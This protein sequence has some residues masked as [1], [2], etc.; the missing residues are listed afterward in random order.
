MNSTQTAELANVCATLAGA[1]MWTWSQARKRARQAA[2][3]LGL[4]RT[5]ADTTLAAAWDTAQSRAWPDDQPSDWERYLDAATTLME[6]GIHPAGPIDDTGQG[7]YWEAFT[8]THNTQPESVWAVVFWD[9]A[10]TAGLLPDGEGRLPVCY[11]LLPTHDLSWS[12]D[13][14]AILGATVADAFKQAG[15]TCEWSG[16]AND[17]IV[18]TNLAWRATPTPR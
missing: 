17:R 2:S 12:D 1:G 11:S 5:D 9:A 10:D 15:F 6:R 3:R 18:L 13:A 16:D 7:L 8:V 14:Q 4:T